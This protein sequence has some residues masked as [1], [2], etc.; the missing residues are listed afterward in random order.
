[1]FKIWTN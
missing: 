1:M